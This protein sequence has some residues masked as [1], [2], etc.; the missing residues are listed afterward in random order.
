MV[1]N[2]LR[3]KNKTIHREVSPWS[4]SGPTLQHGRFEAPRGN[5]IKIWSL[6]TSYVTSTGKWLAT[7]LRSGVL[8]RAN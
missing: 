3:F 4:V 8:R 2:G 1:K 5:A 6:L 7:F